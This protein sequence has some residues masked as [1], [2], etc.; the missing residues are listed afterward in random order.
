MGLVAF[1]N[2]GRRNEE[3]DGLL[4]LTQ[5]FMS[6]IGRWLQNGRF[7]IQQSCQFFESV[8]VPI[9]PNDPESSVMTEIILSQG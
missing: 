9:L 3:A 8:F 2:D 1:T 4:K 6:F 7:Q 5:L